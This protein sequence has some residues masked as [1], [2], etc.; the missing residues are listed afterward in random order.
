[1]MR[2]GAGVMQIG[3]SKAKLVA[4]KTGVTFDDVAGVDE[5]VDELK[6]IVDF[7]ARPD[8]FRKLG[9]RIAKGVLLVGQT[10]TAKPSH[11]SA[12]AGEANEP[13]FQL[14]GSDFVEMFVGVGAAR[15]RDLFEQAQSKAPC[16]VF[17]DEL[18]AIGKTRGVGVMAGHDERE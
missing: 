13:F 9:G 14:T 2:P 4:E 15:V 16:I 12:V 1:R 3:K 7:L 11:A 5:A 10:V 8:R 18:D 17:I 6:E